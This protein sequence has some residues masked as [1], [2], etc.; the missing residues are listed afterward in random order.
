M[1]SLIIGYGW[2][3]RDPL[4]GFHEK[5]DLERLIYAMTNLSGQKQYARI[6]V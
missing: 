2:T 4:K 1:Y 5:M 6:Y 3:G